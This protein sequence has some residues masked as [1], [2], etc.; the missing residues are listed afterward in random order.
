MAAAVRGRRDDV[1]GVK[2]LRR[3]NNVLQQRVLRPFSRHPFLCAAWACVAVALVPHGESS[4]PRG[5]TVWFW[6]MLGALAVLGACAVARKVRGTLSQRRLLAY[7]MVAAFLVRA[8]YV[9]ATP[10]TMRQHDSFGPD[11][12]GG[13]LYYIRFLME[14]GYSLEGVAPLSAW[15]MYH[16]PLHHFLEAYWLGLCQTLG[17]QG[18][19]LWE[20]AQ[21]PTLFYATAA[22]LVCDRLFCAL[23]V[24]GGA[25][26][27]CDAVVAFHPTFFIFAGS[28]NNDCL[29]TLLILVS[30]L[31]ALR[32]YAAPSPGRIGL[33][34]LAIALA[35]LAKAS[36]LL[37]SLGVACVF[38]AK[39]LCTPR[40][41]L[42][43]LAAQYG[44]FAVVCVPLGLAWMLRCK[45][46][47]D[48]KFTYVPDL[49]AESDQLI[50]GYSVWQRLFVPEAGWWKRPYM[51]LEP[52][53][54]Y[55]IPLKL[56]RTAL[57]DESN[58]Y[59]VVP[60][61][62]AYA[63][64]LLG[65]FLTLA[66]LAATV[67]V[68]FTRAPLRR[69]VMRLSCAVSAFVYGGM[70]VKF[71]FEYPYTCTP[72]F[73]YLVPVRPVG[74]AFLGVWLTQ[75]PRRCPEKRARAVE[76]LQAVLMSACVCFA[77]CSTAVYFYVCRDALM[78]G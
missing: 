40:R 62:L 23:G 43:P 25:R 63:L 53:L 6:G 55:N 78:A 42:G 67:Y 52:S 26:L 32:W 22:T 59:P 19:A 76:S 9:L 77:L 11:D 10:V 15:Q 70:A 66:T 47:Y 18:N 29:C 34:A 60:T 20:L 39:L 28:I 21:I 36:G 17:V 24:R 5:G 75:A 2:Q 8:L 51:S 12:F 41:R 74:M 1:D 38:L 57:F 3:W 48:M 49:G 33:L 56:L 46:L 54:N 65:A 30:M 50:A 37:V 35:G 61:I 16:P 13:H 71:C 14:N 31:W 27:A 45:L 58:Y 4:L 73:R 69:R 64:L 7:L 72:N 68:L 44:L